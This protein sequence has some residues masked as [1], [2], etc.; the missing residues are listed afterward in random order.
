MSWIYFAW[1]DPNNSN[2]TKKLAFSRLN[3]VINSQRV[4]K[5]PVCEWCWMKMWVVCQCYSRAVVRS[6]SLA[7]CCLSGP[8][9]NSSSRMAECAVSPE[10]L[11][12]PIRRIQTNGTCEPDCKPRRR[13]K[14]EGGRRMKVQQG[15]SLIV[16]GRL[17]HSCTGLTLQI[18]HCL[19]SVSTLRTHR[20]QLIILSLIICW[21][22]SLLINCFA[23]K[24]SVNGLQ[25]SISQWYSVK[26]LIC[27]F[28]VKKLE[29]IIMSHHGLQ[30]PQ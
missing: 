30:K 20:N 9:T 18:D 13:R 17:A 21:L 3:R 29:V 4:N 10:L 2:K 16:Y 22:T 19:L 25:M 24:N 1:I 12:P 28:S 14:E 7:H 23:Y 27:L 5:R 6:G 15:H 26:L 8:D 11:Q